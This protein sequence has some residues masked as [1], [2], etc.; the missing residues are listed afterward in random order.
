M[1]KR[2]VTTSKEILHNLDYEAISVTLDSS[3]IG[4]KVV[5]AGTVLAGVSESV[6]KDRKQKVKAVDNSADY[7]DGILL[8][9]VDLTNGDAAG[10]CVYRGTINA[11]KLADSS[12]AGNYENLEEVLPHIQFI[13]GGK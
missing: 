5:P 8:T 4:N 10:S 3:T 9:D 1:N 6:F 11:D 13:K 12:V 2:K 7:I